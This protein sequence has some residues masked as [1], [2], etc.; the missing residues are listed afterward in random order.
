[1]KKFWE[2]LTQKRIA[3]YMTAGL[4]VIMVMASVGW[5][6]EIGSTYTSTKTLGGLITTNA[7]LAGF[8]VGGCMLGM[9]LPK[10]KE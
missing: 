1:M 9:T 7:I 6:K 8:W 3:E 2:S 10:D 4:I 5:V